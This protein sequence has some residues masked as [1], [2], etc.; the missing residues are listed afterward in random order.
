MNTLNVQPLNT[1]EKY[2]TGNYYLEIL[3]LPRILIN[4]TTIDQSKL[5]SIDI[6]NA[7]VLQVRCL[8][9]GDGS[10]LIKRNGKLEWVCNL[11]S[12]T[13]QTFFLQPGNYIAVWRAKALRGSIYTVERKF[14]ISSDNQSTVEFYK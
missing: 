3:T 9:A 10:I 1:I 13:Q 14:S 5:K 6:P 8:E 11:T 4:Q 7:G 2:I 12:Q